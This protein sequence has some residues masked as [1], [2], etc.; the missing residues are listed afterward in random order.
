MTFCDLKCR[1]AS[2]PDKLA[3]GSNSCRT[4]VGLWCALKKKLV[5]KNAPCPD[6][7]TA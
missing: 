4:F 2:W 3:D 7:E 1:H 6:K 5:Y